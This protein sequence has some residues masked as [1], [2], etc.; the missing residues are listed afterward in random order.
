[1]PKMP[2]K[3]SKSIKSEDPIQ[4]SAKGHFTL[5]KIRQ[6]G[7]CDHYDEF[8]SKG[9]SANDCFEETKTFARISDERTSEDHLRRI[10][11]GNILQTGKKSIKGKDV[12]YLDAIDK[13]IGCSPEDV[14][15]LQ[16]IKSAVL[17]EKSLSD[18]VKEAFAETI[19]DK[20]ARAQAAVISKVRKHSD[21]SETAKPQSLK[22]HI[23]GLADS[24]VRSE[25]HVYSAEEKA[26]IDE[27]SESNARSENHEDAA[28]KMGKFF[29][30][31][32]DK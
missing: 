26:L 19:D 20:I 3:T 17:D 31:D 22:E 6:A 1:M 5:E 8:K 21:K 18:E 28:E 4:A 13:I 24:E 27:L 16:E 29:F 7:I 2:K 9:I 32:D 14:E 11:T 23:D 15:K 10:L 12:E 30:S 25:R